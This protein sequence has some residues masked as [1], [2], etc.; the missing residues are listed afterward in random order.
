MRLR[1]DSPLSSNRYALWI[2][3]ST[4][5][6]TTV[7][8]ASVTGQRLMSAGGRENQINR[9]SKENRTGLPMRILLNSE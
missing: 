1:M 3:W 2:N 6:S 5:A 9:G 7:A 4:M 8:S